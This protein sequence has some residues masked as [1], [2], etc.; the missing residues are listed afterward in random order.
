MNPSRS[1]VAFGRF[2]ITR[3]IAR[4]GMAEIYR[5]RTRSAK[6]Q[7]ARWVAIKMMRS[8]LGH[9]ELRERLFEREVRIA[10]RLNHP[11]VVPVYEFGQELG[12]P[13]LA[14]EYIRGRDLAHLLKP[15]D[16]SDEPIPFELGL[17]IGFLAA[18]GLGHAHR[19]RDE[20]TKERLDIVHRDVSPGNVMV[21][22][23]GTVKVLDF[24]VARINDTQGYRTQTG[25]LRGKFAYMSPE[26]TV[27]EELDA[28][29]DVF[30]FGTVLYEL[31]T[32]SNCFR[33]SNPI[34][35]LERVQGTRPVPPS[36]ARRRIPKEVDRILAQCL[37]KDRRRRFPD[38]IAVS[39]AVGE[40]LDRIG[41]RGHQPLVDHMAATFSWEQHEE[42]SELAREEEEV[43]LMEVVDFVPDLTNDGLDS[44]H[45]SLSVQQEASSS[46]VRQV[47]VRDAD[48]AVFEDEGLVQEREPMVV[49]PLAEDAP[50]SQGRALEAAS[51]LDS[52]FG[53]GVVPSGEDAVAAGLRSVAASSSWTDEDHKPTA[54]AAVLRASGSSEP[55]GARVWGWAPALGAAATGLVLLMAGWLL[56]PA[57]T[58]EPAPKTTTPTLRPVTIVLDERSDRS[59]EASPADSDA[60]SAADARDGAEGRT[61][62][63]STGRGAKGPIPAAA[64]AARPGGRPEAPAAQSDRPRTPKGSAR[65]SRKSAAPAAGSQLEERG[66]QKSASKKTKRRSRRRTSGKSTRVAQASGKSRSSRSAKAAREARRRRRGSEPSKKAGTGFL[67]IRAQPWGHIIIDGKRWPYQTPQAGIELPVGKHSIVLHNPQTGVTKRAAVV[68]KKGQ[69]QKLSLDLRRR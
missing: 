56:W 30:S 67:S 35:T 68:I 23:D 63:H 5:A 40:Y 2:I 49:S 8:T 57:S 47:S 19:L 9:E 52:S 7:P 20:E 21:G 46:E 45:I 25:T 1:P 39:E 16:E 27:G 22:Y 12:R 66:A 43:A 61:D 37:S 18:R 31:L 29:S 58:P 36:R 41:Y 3:R 33:T 54:H 13:Y 65:R 17:Y 55:A 59:R 26:Q 32:G 60:R 11:N 64:G 34:T 28:R 62:G 42:A 4:G 69:Y 6:D 50:L 38:G 24:G 44:K 51:L 53:D 48:G 10:T 14:M 15:Q